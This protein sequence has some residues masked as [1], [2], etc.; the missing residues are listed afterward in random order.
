[1]HIICVNRLDFIAF[2]IASPDT[3]A[4]A[5]AGQCLTDVFTVSGQSNPVPSICGTNT[6]QHSILFIR[7]YLL[8]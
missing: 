6:N 3:S 1:M 7:N 2:T 5:T 8:I 4:S